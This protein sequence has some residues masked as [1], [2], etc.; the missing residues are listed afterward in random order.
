MKSLLS[1]LFISSVFLQCC[2][3]ADKKK[4]ENDNP[5][6]G[7]WNF[8]ADQEIDSA[9]N[10]INQ[11]TAVTGL[12]IYT[13]DGRMSIQS[14]WKGTRASMINDSIMKQDGSTQGLGLGSNSWSVEQARKLIDTYDAYFGVYSIDKNKNEVTHTITGNLRPDKA[15]TSYAARSFRIKG[16]TLFFRS[17]YK[18]MRWQTAWLKNK[19]K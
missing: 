5:L 11:D 1:V 13:A 17:T 14:L 8:I 18:D 3:T 10:V 12:L 2:K 15:G 6:T 7:S 16:D 4:S 9:G 19:T